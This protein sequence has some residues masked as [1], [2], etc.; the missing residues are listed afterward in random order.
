LAVAR[1]CTLRAQ[2]LFHLRDIPV[3]AITANAMP[4][5]IEAGKTAGF[6]DYLTKPLDIRRFIETVERLLPSG[7]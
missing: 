2:A 7:E 5:D 4:R 6:V 1:L 3:V